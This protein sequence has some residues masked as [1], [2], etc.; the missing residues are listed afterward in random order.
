[1]VQLAQYILHHPFDIPK[2]NADTQFV[3]LCALD[4]GF[5]N[6]VV[7]MDSGAVPIIAL[8]SEERRVG[9]ECRL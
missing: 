2:I 7:A 9:K 4:I 8:R 5:N 3:E 1:M 6:P